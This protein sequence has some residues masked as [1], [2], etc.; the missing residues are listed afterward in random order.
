MFKKTLAT[1]VLVCTVPAIASA[2]WFLTTQARNVGGSIVSDNGTQTVSDGAIT[3]SYNTAT[4]GAITVAPAAGNTVKS[5]LLTARGVNALGNYST[6]VTSVSSP[7]TL[8]PQDSYSYNVAATF[9]VSKLSVVAGNAGGTVSPSSVGNVYYGYTL[10]APLTF[11]FAPMAGYSITSAT[12]IPAGATSNIPGGVN[13]RAT[14]TLPAGFVFTG[15]LDLE[16]VTANT[17][18]SINHILPQTVTD[19][20]SVV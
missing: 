17:T 16:A 6:S 12:G 1:A 3:K 14:V 19:R 4:P 5:I 13:Q 2:S 20:K 18:P 11:T 9:Q 15:A 10:Q 7:Y 8:V